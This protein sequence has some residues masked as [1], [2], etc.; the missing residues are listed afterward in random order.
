MMR[1]ALMGSAGAALAVGMSATRTGAKE[2]TLRM[3]TSFLPPQ[4]NVPKLILDVWA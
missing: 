3:Q 2:V 1:R 4:A